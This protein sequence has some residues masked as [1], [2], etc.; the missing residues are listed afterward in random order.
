MA[1]EEVWTA[2][3]GNDEGRWL[4]LRGQVGQL[5][6]P[7]IDSGVPRVGIRRLIYLGSPNDVVVEV[8]NHLVERFG[9]GRA[10]W[11]A[12][13]PGGADVQQAMSE[14]LGV[15]QQSVSR[16]VSGRSTPGL[17]PQGWTNLVRAR[18]AA[19]EEPAEAT[20]G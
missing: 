15:S 19:L 3:F 14:M 1:D 4:I 2:L 10:G 18:F 5:P 20:D 9:A 16:Y 13:G 11:A 6:P 8:Y 12:G 17:K 7:N